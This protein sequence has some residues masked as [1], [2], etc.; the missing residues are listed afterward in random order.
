MKNQYEDYKPKY[1]KNFEAA[2]GS[3]SPYWMGVLER[4]AYKTESNFPYNDA[5][6]H[7]DK[8]HP[9]YYTP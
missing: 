4:M 2:D 7:I 6:K 9:R 5:D 8:N 3:Q 1:Q